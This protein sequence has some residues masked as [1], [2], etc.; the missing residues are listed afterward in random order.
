VGAYDLG[1]N[2]DETRRGLLAFGMQAVLREV[3]CAGQLA[4]MYHRAN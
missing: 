3:G 1:I 4:G 2:R